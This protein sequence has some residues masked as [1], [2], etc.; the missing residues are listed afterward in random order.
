ML[1]IK[2]ITKNLRKSDF[3]TNGSDIYINSNGTPG[4]IFVWAD[5]CSHCHNFMPTYQKICKKLNNNGKKFPC[6][7][8]EHKELDRNL[9]NTLG[10][11][12]FPTLLWVSPE[13]KIMGKYDG[14]R[15]E[16]SILNSICKVYHYCMVR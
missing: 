13:G 16:S 2:N 3:N 4:L 8:I 5:F 11:N 1:E 12:S 14:S 15:D 10:I 6:M 7:A 9:S